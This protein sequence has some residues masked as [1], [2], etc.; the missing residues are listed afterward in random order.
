MPTILLIEDSLELADSVVVNLKQAGYQV[1]HAADGLEGIKQHDA[2]KPDL[3]ILDWMLPG[4]DGLEV[5]KR[6]R[7]GA[8]TPVLMLTA[9]SEEIDRVLGLEVGADDYLTKPFG[10]RE[11]LARV[12]AILRRMEMLRSVIER[13]QTHPDLEETQCVSLKMEPNAYRAFLDGAVLDLSHTEFELLLLLVRH[14]GRVFSRSYLLE[15]LW[16]EQFIPGDRS[17][18]NL[19]LR[20]RKKL[21]KMGECIESL[22]GVGYRFNLPH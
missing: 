15:T 1:Y 18:D 8:A 2:V 17:I 12:H 20:L 22:W 21:G 6:I 5:L 3:V 4:L 10:L 16:G 19:I 14:P 13:D 9:K 7:Q 11:L